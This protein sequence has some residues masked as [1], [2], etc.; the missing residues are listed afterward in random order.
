MLTE[1]LELKRWFENSKVVDEN[2]KPLVVYHATPER[3]SVFD[4]SSFKSHF[5]TLAQA[6]ARAAELS[7]MSINKQNGYDVKIIP[8]YLSIHKPFRMN[9]LGD[10]WKSPSALSRE[11]ENTLGL[12]SDSTHDEFDAIYDKIK[13]DTKTIVQMLK[14]RGYD[15]I[16]Y[17]NEFEGVVDPSQFGKGGIAPTG[18]HSGDSYIPFDPAQIK[19][20]VSSACK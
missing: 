14:N 16:V 19:S 11:I 9:D 7:S 3:F 18:K 1:T 4:T 15:G 6:E 2:G 5:G 20:A 17:K 8:V 12:P 13:S 10:N